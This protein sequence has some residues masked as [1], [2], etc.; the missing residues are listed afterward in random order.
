[1]K[2][3]TLR[4]LALIIFSAAAVLACCVPAAAGQKTVHFRTS[5]NCRIEAFYLAPSSGSYVFIN[6]HGLGS[7]KN[8]WALFQ[9]AIK[10][11]GYGYLSLDLR[12]HGA[13]TTCGGKKTGYMY[14]TEQDWNNASRDIEAAAAYVKKRGIAPGRLVFCGASVGANLALKA[15]V[16]GKIKPGA[17]VLLSPGL[18]YAGVKTEKY[19]IAPRTFKALIVAAREDAYAWESAAALN[20]AAMGKGLPAYTLEGRGGHGVNMFKT[21]SVIPAIMSWLPKP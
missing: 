19:F 2:F 7:D 17:L 11:A 5:D 1:M 6:A 4:P 9:K 8:E 21:P 20:R 10:S 14:F 13:S 15:A 18:S 12:G 16:E 3:K